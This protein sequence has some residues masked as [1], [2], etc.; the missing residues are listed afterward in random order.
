MPPSNE[1]QPLFESRFPELI[2]PKNGWESNIPAH[3]LDGIDPQTE[4]LLNEISKNTQATNFACQAVV[5]VSKHLRTLNGRVY[6]GEEEAGKT[7]GD[8]ETLKNQA[9][10]VTPFLK[11]IS[12]FAALW[13]YSAFKWFFVGGILF[14]LFVLYPWLLKIGLLELLDNYLKGG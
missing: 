1:S 11:P 7:K 5:D 6:K 12:M 8:L 13:E 14:F 4:W 9:K 10:A 2:L 3:L